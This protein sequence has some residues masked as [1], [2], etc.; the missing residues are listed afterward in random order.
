[1][2]YSPP[3]RSQETVVIPNT[4]AQKTVEKTKT[5][6]R[7]SV[8]APQTVCA[9]CAPSPYGPANPPANPRQS[10]PAPSP[11]TASAPIYGSG[12]FA[13]GAANG[14]QPTSEGT[15]STSEGTQPTSEGHAGH[16]TSSRDAEGSADAEEAS[17][18]GIKGV[19]AGVVAVVVVAV[20]GAAF[21]VL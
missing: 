6:S 3:A 13:T 14:T 12:P 10:R 4:P 5:Q 21:L 8:V 9:A 20:G 2:P 1:M 18:E 11:E 17:G 15:Q 7:T 19:R 16:T